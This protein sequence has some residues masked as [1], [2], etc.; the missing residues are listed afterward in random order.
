MAVI[1]VK[2]KFENRRS[3]KKPGEITHTR[4]F[5]VQCDERVD[6]TAVAISGNDGTTAIPSLG[7]DHPKHTTAKVIS[8]DGEPYNQHDLLF[9]V[10]V[11][12]STAQDKQAQ[13]ENP[14]LRPAEIVW[15][16]T[17]ST[18]T[19]FRDANGNAVAN[20]AGEP[21]QTL[22]DRETSELTISITRNEE[23]HNAWFAESYSH[24]INSN[25]VTIDGTSFAPGVLKLSP[26][27]ATK[28]TENGYTFYRVSYSIKV[29]RDGWKITV[30]D[31]GFNELIDPNPD[32]EDVA[33][34]LR[35][36]VDGT[37]GMPIKNPWP[38]DGHGRKKPNPDDPPAQGQVQPY[39]EKDWSALDFT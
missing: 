23:T 15:G 32:D 37:T 9:M 3:G 31:T 12:Y 24:T 36:I 30:L 35:P 11:E 26:I 29:R 28:T 7:D 25:I 22:L 5:L 6:G 33:K 13:A 39:T 16:S 17:E 10:T 20:S 27:T 19:F 4:V 34:V 14:L 8:I 1:S 38:L 2:E 21:F 18:E